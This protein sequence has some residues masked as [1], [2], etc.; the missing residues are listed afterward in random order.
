MKD[1]LPI[2]F[3]KKVLIP[4]M[5]YSI[6][7]PDI[8]PWSLRSCLVWLR[9]WGLAIGGVIITPIFNYIIT[10]AVGPV[11]DSWFNEASS[12][13]ISLKQIDV[14]WA[15]PASVLLSL[16]LTSLLIGLIASWQVHNAQNQRD[17]AVERLKLLYSEFEVLKETYSREEQTRLKQNFGHIYTPVDVREGSTSYRA[18]GYIKSAVQS[19]VEKIE[20][21]AGDLTTKK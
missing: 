12:S 19:Q 3:L 11:L 6:S 13:I 20:D 1:E 7:M 2:F 5:P 18:G 8:S 4:Q 9:R 14:S 21:L 15:N 10:S 17:R 16:L